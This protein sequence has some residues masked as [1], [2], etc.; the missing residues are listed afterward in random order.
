MARAGA[1]YVGNDAEIAFERRSGVTDAKLLRSNVTVDSDRFSFNYA[2][3][4]LQTGDRVR[5]TRLDKAGLES[6]P[7]TIQSARPSR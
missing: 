7:A 4:V 2:D 5:I 1:V 6:A 3:Y